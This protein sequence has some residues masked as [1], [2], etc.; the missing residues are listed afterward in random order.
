MLTPGR[1]AAFPF[2]TLD[3]P[4][5]FV[6]L[7]EYFDSGRQRAP[8]GGSSPMLGRRPQISAN[9]PVFADHYEWLSWDEVDLRR[10]YVGSG[11]TKL[12]ADGVAG[13]SSLRLFGIYSGNCPGTL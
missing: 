4:D 7:V 1:T 5:A 9:P 2:L 12:Y 8:A 3:S 10:Q 6:N 13:G 11:L